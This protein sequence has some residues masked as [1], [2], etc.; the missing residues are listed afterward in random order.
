MK[1]KKNPKEKKNEKQ[2]ENINCQDCGA[3]NVKLY[4]FGLCKDCLLDRFKEIRIEF[5][6][7]GL[8]L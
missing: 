4:Q 3:S 7:I 8:A 1:N 5:R 2:K 6:K